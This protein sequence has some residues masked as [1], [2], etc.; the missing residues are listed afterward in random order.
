MI[1]KSL[2]RL[3]MSCFEFWFLNG[4]IVAYLIVINSTPGHVPHYDNE[5][6]VLLLIVAFYDIALQGLLLSIAI[7]VDLGLNW[8]RNHKLYIYIG[9]TLYF[10]YYRSIVLGFENN[11]G[12]FGI[13]YLCTASIC[14]AIAPTDCEY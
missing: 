3:L 1:D 8:E 9:L 12:E 2:F 5:A 13:S 14:F 6:N 11:S 7:G 10:L 4:Q